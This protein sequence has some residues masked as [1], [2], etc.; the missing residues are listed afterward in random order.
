MMTGLRVACVALVA[1]FVG[2]LGYAWWI[3][4]DGPAD[5]AYRRA[6]RD[7][8]ATDA[9]LRNDLL[10]SRSG[11]VTNYDPLVLGLRALH[12][13]CAQLSTPPSFL[14]GRGRAALENAAADYARELATAEELIESFK[15]YNA[16]LRNSLRFFPGAGGAL[17]DRLAQH[18]RGSELT[19]ELNSLIAD[20][21]VYNTFGSERLHARLT[22]QI[23]TVHGVDASHVDDAARDSLRLLLNHAELIAVEKPKVDLIV[24]AVVELPTANKVRSLRLLYATHHGVAADSSA[25]WRL[26]LA[27]LAMGVVVTGAGHFI[28]QVRELADL[29]S[30]F[31]SMTSHEFRTPLSV[32]LSSAELL[33]AYGDR[34]SPE[35]KQGHLTR[36]QEAAKDM[37]TM[38]DDVLMIGRVDAGMLEFNPERVDFDL[39]CRELVESLRAHVGDAHEII[40]NNSGNLSD[41]SVDER[42]LAHV[43]DNLLSNA[44]KYSPEGGLVRFDV[45]RNGREMVVTVED[46]GIGISEEDQ[47]RLFEV[48]HRGDNVGHLS[49]TGL[50]LAIVKSSLDVHRASISVA[51]ELGKGSRFT[52]RVP[53]DH[54]DVVC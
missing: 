27:L 18:H 15:R 48:F 42:L 28:V 7:L 51:S 25:S 32:I 26:V 34:W 22:K 11:A 13:G 47:G 6:M 2:G 40:Y 19:R 54:C 38:L 46:S 45:S 23:H 14:S 3:A 53:L 37:N 17:V 9:M 39:L 12:E 29:R 4:V 30:R 50:G 49:G 16:V 41:V 35:K 24:Q 44:I 52:V 8:G 31:V 36:V 43:F 20:L 21:L 10:R 5:Q 1:C 33:E